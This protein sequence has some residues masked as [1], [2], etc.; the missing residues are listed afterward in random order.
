M[1]TFVL[2]VLASVTDLTKRNQVIEGLRKTASLIQATIFFTAFKAQA[3]SHCAALVFCSAHH[4]PKCQAHCDLKVWH[5]CNFIAQF[6][7]QA[8]QAIQNQFCISPLDLNHFLTFDQWVR[9]FK[10]P[11]KKIEHRSDFWLI[12]LSDS[13]AQNGRCEAPAK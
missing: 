1:I 10:R 13:F 2:K 12:S 3:R 8:C 4:W 9:F 7:K 6:N 11:D 5:S